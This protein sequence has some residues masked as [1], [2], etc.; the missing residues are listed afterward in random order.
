MRVAFLFTVG[1]V[2]FTQVA[3]GADLKE[4]V[5][6]AILKPF[7]PP[8]LLHLVRSAEGAQGLIAVRYYR[9]ECKTKL[10]WDES[11]GLLRVDFEPNTG[12]RNHALLTVASA[13]ALAYDGTEFY[14]VHQYDPIKPVR[15]MPAVRFNVNLDQALPDA[16]Q[17]V[18]PKRPRFG[19]GPV[20][21]GPVQPEMHNVTLDIEKFSSLLWRADRFASMEKL[22]DFHSLELRT[23]TAGLRT[24]RRSLKSMDKRFGRTCRW[25]A[26]LTRR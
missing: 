25:P 11:I 8:S 23:T 24:L 3:S 13:L 18:P 14:R 26:I 10:T 5:C 19:Q 4:R 12:V 15:P 22:V 20:D 9:S 1:L 16:M 6:S 7:R 2:F 21:R 17:I